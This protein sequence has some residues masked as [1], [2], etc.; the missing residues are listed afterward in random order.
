M[1]RLTNE[2]LGKKTGTAP[3]QL[4]VNVKVLRKQ[5]EVANAQMNYYD[6]KITGLLSSIPTSIRNPH[7]F[8]DRTLATWDRHDSFPLF[9]FREIFIIKTGDLISSMSNSNA[10]GHDML[11]SQGIKHCQ[12]QLVKQIRHLINVSLKQGKFS[13]KWKFAKIS[14]RLKNSDLDKQS[15]S[16]YRPVAILPVISKLVERAAKTQL[17]AFLKSMGTIKQELSCLQEDL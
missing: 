15:A 16:S 14:P 4:F 13:Q 10:L 9:K 3:Q 7:R 5:I 8:L 17:L 2:I 11:D 12:T 1:Y 6:S